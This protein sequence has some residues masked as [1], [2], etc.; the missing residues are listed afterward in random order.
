M[1]IG[2]V[3]SGLAGGVLTLLLRRAGYQVTLVDNREPLRS[4]DA[5]PDPRALAVTPA[6][7]C[8][9]EQA[10]VWPQ[11]PPDRIGHLH[12]MQVWDAAGRGAIRFA[13]GDID[14]PA[15]GYIIEAGVMQY[16][17][18]AALAGDDG[19]VWQRPATPVDL[20]FESDRVR[21]ELDNGRQLAARLLVAAD[22]QQSSTRGLAG[23][24]YPA[25]PYPQKAV[26]AV[27]ETAWPHEMI[28]RQRFL[29]T[30]PLAFLPMAGSHQCGIVW[31]TT[32]DHAETLLAMAD[33]AF[34]DAAATAF[35]HELGRINSVGRRGAFPL[36]RAQAARYVR[37]R[38]ALVGDAAHSLHPLAGQGAN[39]GWLDVACLLEV[40]N[41][42]ADPGR[43]RALRRYERWRRS[44]N[45]IM[46][47]ALDGL[48]HLFLRGE[49]P[50]RRLRNM[51]LA[52][53]DRSGP[54]KNYLMRYAMGRAGD[55]PALARC[56]SGGGSQSR[57]N[58]F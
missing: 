14:E 56:R 6:S 32:P 39:M 46:Q 54:V 23:I 49:W 40:L 15:L 52:M 36:L 20:Q 1:D 47:L 38:F 34:A 41:G 24:H 29:A 21:L 43:W 26:A 37:E 2:V 50:I 8:I 5:R 10:R 31:S 48:H 30:G 45:Y 42:A 27:V 57:Q 53:T 17:I 4:V 19:L 13:A 12:G 28:A 51:G 16:A 44:D 58:P 7:R 55:L 25:V 22:G 33:D 18:D 11:L 9:L 35:G 3:G